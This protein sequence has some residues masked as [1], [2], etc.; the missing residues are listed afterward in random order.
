MISPA[1]STALHTF[2]YRATSLDGQPISGTIEA[3]DAPQADRQLKSLQL[4]VLEIKSTAPPGQ[5]RLVH[6]EDFQAFNQ[7]LAMLARAGMPLEQGLKLIADEMSAG[8]LRDTVRAVVADLESGASL[9]QAIDR[10]RKSFPPL[11]AELLDA[12]IRT[13]N[14]PG[15]LMNLGGHLILVRRMRATLWR[16]LSYP[17]IVLCAMV[18]VSLF[19]LACVVPQFIPMFRDFHVALPGFTELLFDASELIIGYWAIS[20]GVLIGLAVIISSVVGW[21]ALPNFRSEKTRL[22]IPVIGRILRGNL[23]SRWCDAVALGVDSGIDLPGAIHLADDVIGSPALKVDGESIISAVTNGRK[24]D[25]TSDFIILPQTVT[26]AMDLASASGNL[27]ETLRNLSEM[28]QRQAEQ[29]VS[30]IPVIVT[31]ALVLILGLM[32]GFVAI[33]LFAPFFT[34]IG[35]M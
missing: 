8:K 27:A 32:I 5:Y 20:I 28:Y 19:V 35:I 3:H 9:P 33:A 1:A 22:H 23:V 14:L 34:L 6:G 11:Y 15:I 13:G 21:L 7:Q 17:I 29:R 26:V 4:N 18:G 16:A 2:A 10:H 30:A 12:G 24:F 25:Q 31:P